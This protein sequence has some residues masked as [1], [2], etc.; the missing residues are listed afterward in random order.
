MLIIET[1]LIH[2]LTYA[3]FSGRYIYYIY[4]VLSGYIS[5]YTR[6]DLGRIPRAPR[7]ALGPSALGHVVQPSGFDLERKKPRPRRAIL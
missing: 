4:G 6:L 7:F 3:S 2:V 1:T 5:Q